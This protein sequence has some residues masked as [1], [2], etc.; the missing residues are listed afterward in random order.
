MG[1]E[2][3]LGS[4]SGRQRATFILKNVTSNT[5]FS[6]ICAILGLMVLFS[7]LSP[8]FL[9]L[10][11]ILNIGEYASIMGI[12]AVGETM[13]LIT[14]GFDISVA[15]VAAF[16]GMVTAM[17][18]Q[19]FEQPIGISILMGLLAGAG[20][21]A[22]NA[23]IHTMLKIN[24]LITTLATMSIFRSL[25][26]IVSEGK[27]ITIVND[28]FLA[29][30]RSTILGIPSC[31]FFMIVV[32]IVMGYV[33]SQTGF[34]RRLY[35]IGGNKYASFLSGIN[36]TRTKFIM[37]IMIGIFSGFAG[38]LMASQTG[39]GLTNAATGMEMNVIAAAR[40][41]GVSLAGGKGN[42][43]GTFLGVFLLAMIQNGMVMINVQSYY[44][45]LVKGIILVIS[46]YIDV[47]RNGQDDVKAQ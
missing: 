36:I 28:D 32:M 5:Q 16:C 14:G 31:F 23:F 10:N 43:Q 42:M 4:E 46:V 47:L 25:A 38:I 24:P 22:A 41:G 3:R 44:Q 9:S 6:V 30:G 12:L 29:I 15:A 39:A 40:L 2:T 34:G 18:I 13:A 35:S 11:N 21:G 27:T 26:Y 45:N 8:Y 20:A 37:F 19:T 7:V 33:L 17:F 1:G